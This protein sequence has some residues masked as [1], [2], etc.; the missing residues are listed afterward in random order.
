M[1][2]A[3][4][5]KDNRLSEKL[6]FLLSV[7]LLASFVVLSAETYG[8]YLMLVLTAVIMLLSAF[9][10]HGRLRIRIDAYQYFV[11]AFALFCIISSIWA[12]DPAKSIE[13]GITVIKLLVCFWVLYNHYAKYDSVSPLLLILMWAGIVVSFYTIYDLG[14][15]SILKTTLSGYRLES[16]YANINEISGAAASSAVIAFFYLL[17]R[18]R[19]WLIYAG[20][21]LLNLLIVA[22]SGSRKSLVIVLMGC[23]LIAMA[24]KPSEDIV[25]TILR[26]VGVILL[27]ILI[28]RLMFLLPIFDMARERMDGM[29]AMLT[30]QGK[31]DASALDR[32]RM[33]QIGLRQFLETPVLGI[34]IGNS[35]TITKIYFHGRDTYLHNN[36]VELLAT[37]GIV[38]FFIYYA[39]HV[40]LAHQF[41][42][43]RQNWTDDMKLCVVL[44]LI[45][46]AM[47]M[48][49]VSYYTKF[50]YYEFM[51]FFLCVKQKIFQN[52]NK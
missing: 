50:I 34:G 7:L 2:F 24:R 17:K 38:G 13:K 36:F 44:F 12:I 8:R 47:D 19:E 40:Y 51:M 41:W 9:Q 18:R 28:L 43:L 1:T 46:T 32:R 14:L 15:S 31:A 25:K 26:G 48:G 49:Q 4:V 29:L 5:H 39:R 11:A 52:R 10:N 27:S 21:I 22:A 45:M 30:G 35:G 20:S 23:F 16:E 33:M 6:I 3:T 42:K 37:G